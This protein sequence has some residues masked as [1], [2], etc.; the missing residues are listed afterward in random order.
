MQAL[1]PEIIRNWS[2]E[3]AVIPDRG[4]AFYVDG[5]AKP[6]YIDTQGEFVLGR[7]AGTTTE[8]LLDLAPFG[9][10]SMGLS[11]RHVIIRR[12]GG[13]YEVLDLGSVNG[14]WMNGERLV[15]HTSY[16]LRS[17][18]YLRLGRMVILVLYRPAPE[19]H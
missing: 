4:I 14:T 16:P 3:E 10:Y 2:L 11:R 15:P 5:Y 18:S 1:T 17:G 8:M 12:T 13:T 19:T 6:A 9:G 7:R